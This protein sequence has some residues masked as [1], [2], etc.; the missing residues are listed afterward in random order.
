MAL[1]GAGDV[2]KQ[3]TF[4]HRSPRAATH[5]LDTALLENAR[6]GRWNEPLVRRLK[7]YARGGKVDF[8]D[9]RVDLEPLTEFQRRVVRHCRQIPYGQTRSYGQLAAAAG[10]PRAA[11]AVGNCMAGNRIPLVI[12]CHRVISANGRIG[13]FSAPD[14]IRTKQRLLALEAR[15]YTPEDSNL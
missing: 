7:A 8:H 9:V 13:R 3:L 10:H 1:I 15:K 6:P 11:R 5:A 12:P 4:A 14:G 2:L